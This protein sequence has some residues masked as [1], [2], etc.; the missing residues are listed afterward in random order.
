MPDIPAPP[1]G[2]SPR[3]RVNPKP[4]PWRHGPKSISD[5]VYA[6]VMNGQQYFVKNQ[7]TNY[8]VGGPFKSRDEAQKLADRMERTK[9]Q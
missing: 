3:S 5:Q 8:T 7:K 4:G 2:A 1:P 9:F 6:V